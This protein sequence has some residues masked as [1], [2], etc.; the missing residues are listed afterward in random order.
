VRAGRDDRTIFE[1]NPRL[2]NRRNSMKLLLALF[3]TIPGNDPFVVDASKEISYDV[4]IS[5]ASLREYVDDIGLFARNMP[6]VVSVTPQGE[7][8]YLYKTAK[9][10]PLSGR[11][12]TDFL[13][14]KSTEGDSVTIYRS[15][16]DKDDNYMSCRVQIRMVDESHTN[17]VVRL[18]IRLSRENASEVHWLA[19]ILGARFIESRM[20]EDLEGMLKEFVERSNIELYGRL[21]STRAER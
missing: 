1:N 10:I 3:L 18:R 2:R 6:G 20:D 4:E 12:E 17:I 9:E 21:R 7:D 8:T 16:D 13:I 14:R 5:R 11:L 15:T 19:P